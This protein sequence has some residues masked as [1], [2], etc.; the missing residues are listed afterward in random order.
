M[1]ERRKARRYEV[2]LPLQVCMSV[3]KPAEFHTAQ[4]RDISRAGIYFHSN[5]PIEAGAGVELTFA[6]PTEQDRGASVL[7]RA[8][9]KAVRISKLAD[10]TTP[11]FGV[12]ATIDRIDFVR[13]V[14]TNAA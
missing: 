14:M 6:L 4:I 3:K 11:L 2:Y 8:S 10:E 7:V 9:A 12:A 13:P 1:G 5:V